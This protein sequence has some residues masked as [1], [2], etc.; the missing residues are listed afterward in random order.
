MSADRQDPTG[1]S[2][3]PPTTNAAESSDMSSNDAPDTPD[4][5]D[6]PVPDP[7]TEFRD[8]TADP[9][10]DPLADPMTN[11]MTSP[12][13][14]PAVTT[15]IPA[16]S[17]QTLP[18][19]TPFRVEPATPV[20]DDAVTEGSALPHLPP[21]TTQPAQPYP[22]YQE[23]APRPALVTVRKGPRPG[24]IMLG[25]LSMLVAAYV[26]VANLTDAD[27]SF[28]LVG[29][30]MIG[31]FGGMLLLVGLAGVVAGRLRR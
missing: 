31:A 26:L 3:T 17:T 10:T 25:L 22:A 2:T 9:M 7:T 23:P 1:D 16:A 5:P 11:S 19:A 28:R 12:A 24:S 29:P 18:T 15:Q 13:P 21:P 4:T 27:L 14:D 8:P 6:T 20:P 30:T